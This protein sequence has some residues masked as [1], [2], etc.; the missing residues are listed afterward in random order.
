VVK[1]PSKLILL[2]LYA[3]SFIDLAG[4]AI[5]YVI[6]APLI[7]NQ[8]SPFVSSTATIGDRNVIL[9]LLIAAYP[10]TQ[11]FGAPILGDLSDRYGRKWPLLASVTFTGL[12]F[13]LSS[14]ALSLSSLT[15]LFISRFLAGFSSGNLTIAMA[16]TGDL[17][18]AKKRPSYMAMFTILGG[19]AWT[20]APYA[21]SVLS[22]PQ[23]VTWFS[24]ATPFWMIG[25]IFLLCAVIVWSKFQ[26]KSVMKNPNQK[27][28]AIF[29]NL[30]KTLRIPIV[31]P[32]LMISIFT[33]L[34]WMV[35]QGFMSPYLDQKYGFSEEW[36]A[37][38]F[39]SF[40][41]WW[42]IGGLL[43]NQWLLK[44]YHA[45]KINLLPMILAPFFILSYQFF[46]R[47]E[48]MWYASALANL[49]EAIATACFFSLFSV[50]T[51]AK[52]QGKVFGFWNAGFAIC[53]GLGP[54]LAGVLAVFDLNLPFFTAFVILFLGCIFYLRWYFNHKKMLRI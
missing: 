43:A 50:M 34:G 42:L 52:I 17:V 23:M 1:Q 2:V 7:I 53:A 33:M 49:V 40:C 24:F 51:P 30:L 25:L 54:I 47:S 21:G 11:F 6:F 18:V 28:G 46:T 36:I 32:L 10:L 12:A 44:K 22:N 5:V 48:G 8:G 9:G 20:I 14:I 4:L 19:L 38:S 37:K 45:G 39:T 15:L 31:S 13:F 29:P 41:A 27:I 16:T 3:I 26:Q 35:Y